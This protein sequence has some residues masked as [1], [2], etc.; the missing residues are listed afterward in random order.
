LNDQ[1]TIVSDLNVGLPVSAQNAVNK[2]SQFEYDA[3]G[4]LKKAIS[5]E[6]NYTEYT[7]NGRGNVT[8]TV[9]VGKSTGVGL[10]SITAS[11]AY[12]ASCANPKTCNQPESTTDPLGKTTDY[13]YDPT[14][15]GVTTVTLPA[16]SANAP[17][18]QT[19]YTY[20][21]LHAVYKNSGGTLVASALPA[22]RLTAV[23]TCR[24]QASCADTADESRT[25]VDYGQPGAAR[26]LLP[27]T[28]TEAAGNGALSATTRLDYDGV[29]NVVAVNGPT[30]RSISATMRCGSGRGAFRPIPMEAG[31]SAA[32]HPG[33]PT[34]CSAK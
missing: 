32:A 4:R 34:M 31:R 13:S 6:G 29:G 1:R 26:N 9:A 2:T 24:T 5:P 15:G 18:P 8:A 20:D 11:A 21:P 17:R 16:P 3:A 30:T 14:H 22:Y 23:S 7:Y 28:V 25:I 27:E 10:A 12:P 33:R 19:R